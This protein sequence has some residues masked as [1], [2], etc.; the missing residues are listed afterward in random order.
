MGIV[1]LIGF[2]FGVICVVGPGL[3]DFDI[4]ANFSS[5]YTDILVVA[6]RLILVRSPVAA[7]VDIM[8]YIAQTN[9]VA[10]N[11]HFV[12]TLAPPAGNTYTFQINLA[13]NGV[14]QTFNLFA[15]IIGNRLG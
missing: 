7:S 11:R 4:T 15:S 10:I 13:V 12:L 2:I 6:S 5:N 9:Q 14:G 3:W 8:N 1:M